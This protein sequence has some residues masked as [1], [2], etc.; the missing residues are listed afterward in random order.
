MIPESS[1]FYPH[2]YLFIVAPIVALPILA[3]KLSQ[4]MALPA[5]RLTPFEELSLDPA[6]TV[7]PEYL[8]SATIWVITSV[9]TA[10]IAVFACGYS[11]KCIRDADR[12]N[13]KKRLGLCSLLAVGVTV[14][15]YYERSQATGLRFSALEHLAN[16][17]MAK[18]SL[19]SNETLASIAI[20]LF[21]SM[22]AF[23]M[24]ASFFLTFAVAIVSTEKSS[25][26][27]DQQ[28]RQHRA[29]KAERLL[30]LAS[31]LLVGGVIATHFLLKIPKGL[32]P[33][34]QIEDGLPKLDILISGIELQLAA[35]HT[36]I[37][38]LFCIPVLVTRGRVSQGTPNGQ[39]QEE[40]NQ[41]ITSTFW[42][43]LTTY[44]PK[45]IAVLSPLMAEPV[46]QTIGLLLSS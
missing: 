2:R 8:T 32:Y 5:N 19:S 17:T 35:M 43:Q 9:L 38:L 27:G 21:Q 3:M 39:N 22:D 44:A 26:A 10:A 28:D 29:A 25:S 34:E 14:A 24:P 37:L 18:V 13:D 16:G 31:T 11:I 36:F 40:E 23:W 33:A 20:R 1:R 42:R 41:E 46:I 4:W 12:K 45:I 30:Y 6:G 7:N 15:M